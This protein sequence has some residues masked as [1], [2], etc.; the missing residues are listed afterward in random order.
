MSPTFEWTTN[1]DELPIKSPFRESQNT[2]ARVETMYKSKAKKVLPV[3]L[4]NPKGDPPD[5]REDWYE[6]AQ[7]RGGLGSVLDSFLGGWLQQSVVDTW[8]G[9]IVE[10]DGGKKVLISKAGLNSIHYKKRAEVRAN[11]L[12]EGEGKDAVLSQDTTNTQVENKLDEKMGNGQIRREE[13]MADTLR[14]EAESSCG[15]R[16]DWHT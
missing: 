12:N 5:G 9:R 2:V 1:Y 15:E 14:R 10:G 3:Y 13:E 8:T 6:R 16:I 7:E 4:A 11:L